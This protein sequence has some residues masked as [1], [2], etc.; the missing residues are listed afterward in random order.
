MA[1]DIAHDLIDKRIEK[2]EKRLARE[3]N[4]ALTGLRRELND[5]L[6]RFKVN[7]IKMRNDWLNGKI[8]RKDY[9]DWR[10]NRILDARHYN[11]LIKKLSKDLTNVNQIANEIIYNSLAGSYIEAANYTAYTL[12]TTMGGEVSFNLYNKEAVGELLKDDNILLPPLDPA[13]AA[14]IAQKGTQWNMIKIS[15]AVT[16]GILQGESI[17][18]IANRLQIVTDMNRAQALRNA[19]T[20]HNYAENKGR[21]DRYEQAEKMGVVLMREWLAVHDNRTRDA[22]RELDG[23]IKRRGEPFQNSIG[24]IRFP[25]DPQAAPANVYNCRCF[26]RGFILGHPYETDRYTKEGY[27]EWKKGKKAFTQYIASQGWET[28]YGKHKYGRF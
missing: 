25:S 7:D 3:Y 26:T 12:E 17:G 2:L 27:D 24:L 28:E 16:Q 20:L 22:H 10:R 13:K 5:Y 8:T 1:T 19:R 18:K 9:I 11:D 6:N 15:S 14:E 4:T 21:E 23:V